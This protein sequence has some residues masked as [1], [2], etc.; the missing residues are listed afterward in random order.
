M[1][2]ITWGGELMQLKTP[3]PSQTHWM[4]LFRVG[5]PALRWGAAPG[6][7]HLQGTLGKHT[8]KGAVEEQGAFATQEFYA[9]LSLSHFS[10]GCT[11]VFF[12]SFFLFL[13]SVGDQPRT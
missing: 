6:G 8:F 10:L 1:I 13:P 12:L 9:E 5:L 3:G 11:K 4:S 2:R 7:S